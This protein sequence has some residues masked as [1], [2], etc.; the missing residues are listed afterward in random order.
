MLSRSEQIEILRPIVHYS[1][2][3]YD[4]DFEDICDTLDEP[5]YAGHDT[6]KF[7]YDL[8]MALSDQE[9]S[10]LCDEYKTNYDAMG[11]MFGDDEDPLT[12]D[13]LEHITGGRNGDMLGVPGV[14][15]VLSPEM[16]LTS[17]AYTPATEYGNQYSVSISDIEIPE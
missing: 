13:F 1:D 16:T 5:A 8:D 9:R 17:Y 14:T 11:S 15:V 4:S 12:W 2:T 3:M 7:M 10:S 6:V